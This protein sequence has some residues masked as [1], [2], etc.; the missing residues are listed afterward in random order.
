MMAALAFTAYGVHWFAIGYRRHV[1]A[2]TDPDAF[3]SRPHQR[4]G[5]PVLTA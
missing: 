5:H 3:M 1:H 2:S 4:L